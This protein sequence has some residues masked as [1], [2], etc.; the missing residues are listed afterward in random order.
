MS[1]P[2]DDFEPAS[3]IDLLEY[4]NSLKPVE[5]EPFSQ[6]PQGIREAEQDKGFYGT[7]AGYLDWISEMLMY[8]GFNLSEPM[9]HPMFGREIRTLELT[10]AGFST[11]ERLCGLVLDSPLGSMWNSSHVG[12]LFVY[13]ISTKELASDH[14]S[15]WLNPASTLVRTYHHARRIRLYDEHGDYTEISYPYGAEIHYED[16][17]DDRFTERNEALLSI[18]PKAKGP[19]DV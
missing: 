17:V 2:Y 13:Y 14:E 3:Q 16:D 12:G 9:P 7:L 1:N 5:P 15:Q 19:Y 8:K 10:T 11:D 4:I 18:R 6:S